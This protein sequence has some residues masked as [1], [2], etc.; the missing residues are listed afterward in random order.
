[1]TRF[2]AVLFAIT[3]SS[4]VARS[5]PPSFTGGHTSWHGFDRYDFLMDE[6]TFAI[7]PHTAGADEGNAVKTAVK[8]QYRCVVVVPKTAAAG[9]PWSWRGYYFDHEP[10]TEVELLKRGFHIGFVYCDAGKPWDAWYKFLTETHGLSKTPAFVGMSRGGRNAFTWAAANPDKVSCLYVDNPAV[11]RESVALLGGLAKADVPLLHVCGSLDPILGN[12]TLVVESAYQHLG[13]RVSVMIK[14]GAAH[15]P[16]SLRDPKVIADFIEASQK[17]AVSAPPAFVGKTAT[18]TAFYGSESIYREVPSEKTYAACRGP[19]FAPNYDR[20]E[21]RPDGIRMPVA[22]IVPTTP[23]AGKPWVFRGDFVTRDDAVALALLEKGFHVVTGPVPTDTNGPV[24]AQW[25][26]VYK[27]LTDAGL[28]KTPVLAGAGGAAGEAYAWAIENPDKV[29]CVYAENPILRTQMVKSQ[30]LDRLD[31][32]EKAKVPLLHVCGS[33]D[34]W[35]DTQTRALE[36][37]YKDLGGAVTVIVDDGKGHFPTAPRDVKPVV[38]FVLRSQPAQSPAARDYRF[39]RTISR[40]VL[41]NYLARSI[42]VE[43]ILNGRGNLDDNVRMLKDTGAKFI[44][45]ALCL[46]A[47]EANLLKNL[48]RAKEQLPKLHAAE[49][50]L[51]VQACIFEIVTTQVEQVPAPAWAF[52][53]LGRPVETRN[54]RYA[55]MLYPDGRRKDHWRAGQSVP[56]VSRPETKLWFYFLAASYV[57]VGC[58]AIHFGQTELMNGNDKDLKHYGEILALARA[59]AAKKARRHLLICDS[60]VPSGGLVRDG[61]LLMDFHSFPLRIKEIPDKPEEAELKVGHTDAIFGRSKGGVSPSGW[62]CEH[63]PYLV[64]I[65]NYGASRTPG[66][67]G[68]GG[69]WVWGYDEISWFAHQPKEYRAKWLQYAWDWV[70]KTDQNGFLQMP[71]SR[72]VRSPLDGRRWYFANRPSPAVPDGLGDEDAIKAVWAGDMGRN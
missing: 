19:V 69:I 20:Y 1:M 27:L 23:A 65:D 48:E 49:P 39:D 31:V 32:L 55:D 34:P 17:P 54:F 38:E 13:G 5:D 3:L 58:E 36:K 37:R 64:E 63:L 35:L 71:G 25:N 29:S 50:D 33:K 14:D 68:A 2:T 45:R 57:D 10:Q 62:A 22:V 42:S 30:P 21:F 53:A 8:G 60:H 47:G 24:L 15:H 46:W 11:T 41:E 67:A 6:S 28:S 16:H 9:N 70:R 61:K 12:H 56:D 51:V 4:G 52:E 59:Y 7:K 18:R 44:G 40:E 43:G 66:K 26:A 72:T